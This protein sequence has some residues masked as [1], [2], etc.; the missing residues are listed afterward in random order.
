MKNKANIS[1]KFVEYF[2]EFEEGYVIIGGTAL[3]IVTNQKGLSTRATKDY[4]MVLTDSENTANFITRLNQF[5][6]DA[7]YNT[8]EKINQTSHNYYRFT[9]PNSDEF[10]YMLEFF[11][12]KQKGVELEIDNGKT[13]LHFENTDSLSALLLNDEYYDMIEYGAEK[14]EE[15][16][17]YLSHP[18]LIVFK[19]KAWLDLNERKA[20]GEDIKST[21]IKKHIN[22]IFNLAQAIIEGEVFSISPIVFRDITEFIDKVS[23]DKVD[24]AKNIRS[25]LTKVETL[26]LIERM[27]IVA[28]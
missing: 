25:E 24:Y 26:A 2:S 15:G 4:D 27:L 22:D 11:A 21:D 16:L 10:P 9:K 18:F 19:A 1:P 14:S 12:R 7:Q 20:K 17:I 23:K 6:K 13:P 28:N 3:S 8:H 5:I